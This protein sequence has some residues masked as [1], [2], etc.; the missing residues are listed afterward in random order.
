MKDI[1]SFCGIKP[2]KKT[3]LGSVK[4]S[5]EEQRKKWLLKIEEL[6]KSLK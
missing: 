6:G 3:Y 4:T 1:M 5:D 2:V